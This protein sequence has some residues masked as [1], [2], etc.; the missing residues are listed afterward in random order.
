MAI[1][2]RQ[3]LVLLFLSFI[4]NI[5]VYSQASE[6]KQ[7]LSA[8]LSAIEKRF[9]TQFNYAEDLVA[10]LEIVAPSETLSLKET[11]SY[12]ESVTNF[13]FHITDDNTILVI[14]N[15]SLFTMQQLSEIM[16]SGYIVKG[17]NKLSN[18]T[19]E[20]EISDFDI[21]PGLVDTDVL[22][23]VQAFPGIQ[24]INE[25][26]SNINIR[27]GSHDQN[28]ILWDDIKMYQS[29]H[30]FGLISMFNPQITQ[31][32]S[33]TKN[34]SA[35]EYT[36]GVSGI[37]SMQSDKEINNRFKGN[38]GVNFIDAN[39]FVDL[40]IGEKSSLQIAARKSI[41]DFTET[42]TYNN[43]F[44]RISQ[45]TEVENNTMSIV[46]SDKLFDFYDM[47]LRWIYKLNDKE[48]LRINFINVA[49][50]LLFNENATIN[51]IEDS[52]ESSLSQNSIAGSVT[53]SRIWNNKWETIFEGYETD[54][55]LKSINA[56][57]LDSQRF[58]QENKVSETSLKLKS[59]YKINEKL[60]L[61]NGYHFVE[62]E[63]T[64]L[65]DVDT[66][67]FKS[68]VSEVV[69][70]H[71]FFSQLFFKTKDRKTNLSTGLRYNYIEKFGKHL[72]E[73]RLSFSHKFL[74]F[75][76]VEVL[77]EMKHQNTS[78]VINFQNDFLGIEKR[79]WQLSNDRD[80]PV[81]QSRQLSLGISYNKSGWL[82][83]AEGY[84]KKVK[85]ITTQSQGF[86]N[87]YEFVRTSGFNEV[88]GV[89]VLI[90]KRLN[91]F[92][93]WLSYSFI[94]SD[95]IFKSLPEK[96]FPSNF[97]IKHAI[98][99]GTNYTSDRLKISAGLNWNSGRPTTRPIAGNTI[100]N[101]NIN[102]EDTNSSELR[103][104]FRVD[105]SAL[106][107][108][109]L[110]SKTKA[111]LGLSIWNVLDRENI[112]NSFYRINNDDIIEVQQRSLGITPNV[113]FRVNF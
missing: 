79:R 7:S 109:N 69:R 92:N 49:N 27:G 71:G 52:R 20:I 60:L 23:A 18:G 90:R 40:P 53:Y 67:R 39:G 83:S 73:P 61:Q 99:L 48:K 22:Q 44:E 29:G 68:L 55:K 101:D 66:P 6:N 24:S 75:L 35:T 50:E 58:L 45:D 54:Y 108:F 100:L 47:S 28:L 43:F 72:V 65:D 89:D 17:I 64:N 21:L 103:N 32:V 105:I 94:N 88:K 33:L 87:Q 77:G 70:T 59:N 14:V 62:T 107:D 85:G 98:T 10:Q 3:Y 91:N 74:D 56:N 4:F 37:I 86:Q 82:F 80:I 8:I 111:N 16:I 96:R 113:V 78:Q 84:Y 76:S 93:S 1:K 30:F 11:I 57:I 34:G 12:L 36:D 15:A 81:I 110:S 102:Y 51:S 95:Y 26:V 2:I 9:N 106:Y 46:N 97:N 42:P 5:H 19:F 104:Y 25:T 13:S 112:I 31:H 38:I 63:I 41:S